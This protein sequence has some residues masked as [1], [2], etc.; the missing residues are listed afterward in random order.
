M[1]GARCCAIW[2]G[3][4]AAGRR[5]TS[6]ANPSA[7]AAATRSGSGTSAHRCGGGMTDTGDRTAAWDGVGRRIGRHWRSASGGR[8]ASVGG[9]ASTGTASVTGNASVTGSDTGLG[10][11]ASRRT[12]EGTTLGTRGSGSTTGGRR[13]VRTGGCPT[14]WAATLGPRETRVRLAAAIVSAGGSPAVGVSDASLAGAGAGGASEGGSAAAGTTVGAGEGEG[15]GVSPTAV[16]P[17][18]AAGAGGGNGGAAGSRASGSDGTGAGAGAGGAATERDGRKRRGSTY[19]F[20]SLVRRTPRC[21]Y[22]WAHSALPDLPS[23]PI[24][25]PSATDALRLT[26]SEPRWTSVTE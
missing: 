10:S 18:T 12:G 4:E 21:R 22:G 3:A 5:R 7:Q 26:P 6:A 23:V 11:P 19:P 15:G 17:G 13:R 24:G 14:R 8:I 20:G 16:G 25:S 2:A 9:N 1:I